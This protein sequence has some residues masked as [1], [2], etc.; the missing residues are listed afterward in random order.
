MN[1][2]RVR[3]Q[4]V[5]TS[6]I[7]KFLNG[8]S[9]QVIQL[10]VSIIVA[11]LLLPSDFG[12]V[13]LLLVFTS[14]A[15]VFVNS[16]MGT[17]IVQK[18]EI[19]QLEISSVFAYSFGVATLLYLLLY[20]SS[21]YIE[22]FY[23]MEG[24]SIYLRVL[25]LVLLP[26]SYN[27]IQ[28]ALVARKMLWKQQC[29]C[30]IISIIISGIIGI[31]LAYY[32]MGAWAIIWQ[33]LSYQIMVCITLLFVVRWFPAM[34]I[35][36]QKTLPL[37]KY[38]F[39]LLGANLID[40][41]YHN[42]ESLIIGKK[43][44]SSTLAFFT[45]GRMFPLVVTNNV[46]GA[47]QSVMLPVLS[48]KQE[49]TNDIKETLRKTISTSTFILFGV[50]TTLAL[51]ATPMIQILLGNKWLP[52]VPF[53]QWYCL[54]GM[55]FPLQTT[56]AQAINAIGKS[57][58]Y[59]KIM[60]IKRVLGAVLLF[61]FT[62]I[63]NSVYAIVVAAFIVELVAIMI[64]IVYNKLIFDYRFINQIFDIS[65]NVVGVTFVILFYFIFKS[66][67]PLNPF[68]NLIVISIVSSIVYCL[69]LL[70]LKSEDLFYIVNK[71]L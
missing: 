2:D 12:V 42:L 28:N 40:T 32:G 46:D 5:F 67:F 55:T 66:L 51:C 10:V 16:G 54:I 26:G 14:I 13:A 25:A 50:L 48:Q 3:Q 18:K 61:S 4:N 8:G 53:V 23:N 22:K 38:G 19:S 71:F 68:L 52:A 6:L 15:T 33:Q 49:C 70:I 20:M 7:W 37:F 58:I 24:L 34:R 17:A 62:M 9:A 60:S 29:V 1:E 11:R 39:N 41:A 64:H 63:F 35:S 30:N 21:P 31:L 57:N 44:I 69:V 27:V 59:L 43:Y 36:L 45:K 56:S 65:K 47:L